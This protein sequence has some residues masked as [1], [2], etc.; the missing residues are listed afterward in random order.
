MIVVL[1]LLPVVR[2]LGLLGSVG[3]FGIGC[4]ACWGGGVRGVWRI[5]FC[6]FGLG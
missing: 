2:C 1:G 3:W 6:V 4:A 5:A